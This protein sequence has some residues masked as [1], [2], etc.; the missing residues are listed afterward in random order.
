MNSQTEES[1]T[2]SGW[3]EPA[4]ILIRGSA[5]EF[6][7]L[8]DRLVRSTPFAWNLRT[9]DASASEYP[10]VL[11][12]LRVAYSCGMVVLR[13]LGDCLIISGGASG[14]AKLSA[15]LRFFAEQLE[16]DVDRGAHMH[17]EHV[18]GSAIDPASVPLVLSS[19]TESTA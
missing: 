4:E 8:A 7:R 16:R 5:P 11:R 13:L 15:N 18:P 17:L 1:S 9:P 6:R 19:E 2:L 14:F 3:Y 12:N 10:H